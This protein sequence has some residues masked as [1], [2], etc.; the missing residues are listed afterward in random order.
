M[1]NLLLIFTLLVS[2]PSYAEWTEVGSTAI[3]ETFDLDYE[4]VRKHDGYVFFCNMTDYLKPNNKEIC[5]K[6]CTSKVTVN[7]SGIR[8]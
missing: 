3:G 1:K 5:L 6:S 4:R 7:Y 2:S 8:F